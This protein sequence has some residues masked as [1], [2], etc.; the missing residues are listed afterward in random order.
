[1]LS[2]KT[3][4][5]TVQLQRNHMCAPMPEAAWSAAST[6]STAEAMLQSVKLGRKLT[7]VPSTKNIHCQ[8]PQ[9]IC[10][11]TCFS[12]LDLAIRCRDVQAKVLL[13]LEADPTALRIAPGSGCMPITSRPVLVMMALRTGMA[14]LLP[15][16]C[17]PSSVAQMQKAA[18][19]S[20][21]QPR[22]SFTHVIVLLSIILIHRKVLHCGMHLHA[23]AVICMAWLQA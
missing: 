11:F 13:E 7:S 1:M 15:H 8:G 21:C 12:E 20:R 9:F 4:E 14:Q 3:P 18:Q 23:R 19:R 16:A 22:H 10:T 2:N 5:L 17:A 6:A